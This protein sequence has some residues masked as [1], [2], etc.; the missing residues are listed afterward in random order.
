MVRPENPL[1]A[2]VVLNIHERVVQLQP[3]LR[4]TRV[5]NVLSSILFGVGKLFWNVHDRLTDT[6][7]LYEEGIALGLELGELMGLQY[8]ERYGMSI[9]FASRVY[10]IKDTEIFQE[11]MFKQVGVSA[12]AKALSAYDTFNTIGDRL[13]HIIRPPL[14][15]EGSVSEEEFDRW[16]E[17]I[18]R[19]GQALG[20]LLVQPQAS[21]ESIS[22]LMERFAQEIA[23]LRFSS[24]T[25]E[26]IEEKDIFEELH[27]RLRFR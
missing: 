21:V 10:R 25:L 22:T 23:Q 5:D 4:F 18:R 20:S 27:R 11:P 7:G 24:I 2:Q 9:Y 3:N 14:L 26:I 1:P 13:L 15:K 8:V 16:A 19:A 6:R 17:A 12:E